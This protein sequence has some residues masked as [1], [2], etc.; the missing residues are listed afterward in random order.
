MANIVRDLVL[1][2][3]TEG[4]PAKHPVIEA[5][6]ALS[7]SLVDDPPNED[8]IK[9]SL[10][11]IQL[12][13]DIDLAHRCLA[14]KNNA[15]LVLYQVLD[16]YKESPDSLQQVLNAFCALCNGQP[17]V[18]D[19]RGLLLIMKIL[20]EQQNHSEN[21]VAL[22]KLIR[23]TCVMHEKN[24]QAYVHYEVIALFMDALL[25]HKDNAAVVKEICYA[26]RV[27]TYDDDPRVPF[28]KAHDH[29]K[30]IVTEA[31]ALKKI[32][33]ICKGRNNCVLNVTTDKFSDRK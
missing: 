23:L 11:K 18:L 29:A 19:M 14:A 7:K 4:V 3:N 10:T 8:L 20:K 24:R 27:L 22:V 28:G 26:L 6:E 13:C 5:V 15:Y 21:A 30:T 2:D 33:N 32:L 12:E 16:K 31:N 17:D 9:S 1:Q 25:Y